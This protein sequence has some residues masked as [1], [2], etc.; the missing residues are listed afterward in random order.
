MDGLVDMSSEDNVC[1]LDRYHQRFMDDQYFTVFTMMTPSQDWLCIDLNGGNINDGLE[2][3]N[4]IGISNL[5]VKDG[6]ITK[7]YINV[8]EL[9]ENQRTSDNWKDFI[10]PYKEHLLKSSLTLLQTA[11][12]MTKD[13]KGL[14]REK[15]P[16]YFVINPDSKQDEP[17]GL[18]TFWDLNR[19]PAYIYSYAIQTYLE[20]TILLA[21]RDSHKQWEDH[22]Q[23]LQS[24]ESDYIRALSNFLEGGDYNYNALSKL[25]FPEMF[26]FYRKDPHTDKERIKFPEDLIEYISEPNDFRN[27][28]GHPVRL[29]VEDNDKF[30][31]D[32]ERL[33]V[34]WDIGREA[35][36]KFINPKVRHS[37][38]STE[39]LINTSKKQ[40]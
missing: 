29:L 14:K 28:V 3:A 26:E 21:I 4:K 6:E 22:S 39:E 27:R 17:I 12:I 10:K 15:S 20:H 19:A 1:Q 34:I 8:H 5:V 25:G 40:E 11:K 23:V 24:I 9:E 35:F 7:G 13:S 18:M 16:L 32:I 31:D 2:K 30:H 38:P 36:L 33:S 37:T